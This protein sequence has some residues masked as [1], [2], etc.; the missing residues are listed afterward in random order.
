MKRLLICTLLA[1]CAACGGGGASTPAANAPVA[2]PAA[3]WQAA[4]FDALWKKFDEEYT[5][6]DY[7]QIDWNALRASYRPQALAAADTAAWLQTVGA[8]LGQLHD[9]HVRLTGPDGKSIATYVSPRQ[10]NWQAGVLAAYL[11]RWNVQRAGT[12]IAYARLT[13]GAYLAVSSWNE[14]SVSVDQLDSALDAVADAP[15][16]I[17]DLRM[18]PGGNDQLAFALGARFLTRTSVAHIVRTKTGP[19]HNA[20]SAMTPIEVAPRRNTP[21]TRP[22]L[23]LV[24]AQTASS[25]E[26]L[27]SLLRGLPNVLVIGDTTAGASARPQLYQAGNGISFTVSTWQDYTAAGEPIEDVGIAPAIRVDATA[28][29]FAAGRDPVLDAAL[30]RLGVARP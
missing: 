20:L 10:P 24:G 2:D 6:F 26:S 7:K 17:L 11:E 15:T 9:A 5:Y 1:V 29:A 28:A 30:A 21:Y 27:V 16:L 12:S 4:S 23:L 14:Q 25:S 3:S 8:M 18:N 13:G 19:A 22:V